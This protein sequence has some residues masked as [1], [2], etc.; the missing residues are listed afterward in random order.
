MVVHGHVEMVLKMLKNYGGS[1]TCRNDI[2]NAEK[3]WWHMD[4]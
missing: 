4:M 3:L 1:W 2:E